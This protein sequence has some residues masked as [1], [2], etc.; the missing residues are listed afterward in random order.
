MVFF[1][2]KA[3]ISYKSFKAECIKK[4]LANNVLRIDQ[5]S[6]MNLYNVHKAVSWVYMHESFDLLPACTH[7][8]TAAIKGNSSRFLNV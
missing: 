7:I 1:A 3:T 5:L 8:I 2:G 4:I 6:L